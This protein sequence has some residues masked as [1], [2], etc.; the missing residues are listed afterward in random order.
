MKTDNSDYTIELG[1]SLRE[2][3]ADTISKVSVTPTIKG[4]SAAGESNNG[5]PHSDRSGNGRVVTP[6]SQVAPSSPSIRIPSVAETAA[7]EV[8]KPNLG[9]S[10]LTAGALFVPG[11]SSYDRWSVAADYS[12]KYEEPCSEIDF[13][14][15]EGPEEN[16]PEANT[17][18]MPTSKAIDDQPEVLKAKPILTSSALFPRLA[19]ANM[20]APN[21]TSGTPFTPQQTKPFR[22]MGASRWA[23]GSA[24]PRALNG[25]KGSGGRPQ[26]EGVNGKWVGNS[27]RNQSG[28]YS[29]GFF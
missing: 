8:E 7:E 24:E 5:P 23:D 9:L 22:G 26:V 4:N 11:A 15:W 25:P 19:P 14:L 20:D 27:G 13:D 1:Q 17:T 18:A 2:E 3:A 6:S 12:M 28:R 21:A 16:M 10:A 29:S